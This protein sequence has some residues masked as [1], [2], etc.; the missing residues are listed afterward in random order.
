MSTEEEKVVVPAEEENDNE[1]GGVETGASE[2]PQAYFEPVVKLNEVEV[3][4]G[5]ED[6]DV[7]FTIRAKLFDY[8]ETLLNKGTGAKSWCERG[9][10]NVRFLKHKEAGKV[11]LLMRQEKTLK[12]LI[13]HLVESRATLTANM[14]SDRAWVWTCYDFS[15]GVVEPKTFALRFA[16]AENAQ[17]FKDAHED[18]KKSN[19]ALEAGAD[20]ADTTAG[21]EAAKALEGLA[22]KKD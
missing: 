8:K 13:N 11:R 17:A 9:V 18:A 19:K 3:V 5:E 10:G 15:E 7:L 1:E 2:E 16:N 14:G 4:S 22:V 12:I 6:E 20:A 21:D